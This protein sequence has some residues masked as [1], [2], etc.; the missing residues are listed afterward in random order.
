MDAFERYFESSMH[1]PHLFSSYETDGK[2]GMS[3]FSTNSIDWMMR[4]I[5]T[6][7]KVIDGHA[8][9][10]K[11][12]AEKLRAN[13]F[14]NRV[15]SRTF[16]AVKSLEGESCAGTKEGCSVKSRRQKSFESKKSGNFSN[17][18]K[19]FV[20]SNSELFDRLS[21]NTLRTQSRLSSVPQK[22]DASKTPEDAI[23]SRSLEFL[24]EFTFGTASRRTCSARDST[25]AFP[26]TF[27][28]KECK[29]KHMNIPKKYRC[30][31][32]EFEAQKAKKMPKEKARH[33]KHKYKRNKIDASL[34]TAVMILPKPDM[35]ILE[36][37]LEIF[38]GI[39]TVWALAL[40]TYALR[41]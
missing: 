3:D 29:P 18:N 4:D 34:S 5:E 1:N 15:S 6:P 33:S 8:P 12:N 31:C 39:C 9:P 36:V 13:N 40:I 11:E 32:C 23:F 25:K 7:G 24:P 26:A 38:Q 2:E 30:E 37:A 16:E 27:N 19:S 35:E 20:Y 10:K 17:G 41:V 28:K 14:N 21:V 22:K